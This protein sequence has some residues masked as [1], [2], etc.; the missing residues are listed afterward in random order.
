MRSALRCTTFAPSPRTMLRSCNRDGSR[1]ARPGCGAFVNADSDWK[2]LSESDP[3]LVA[4]L[5]AIGVTRL[6]TLPSFEERCAN[7]LFRRASG[8]AYFARPIQG[9]PIKIGYSA[10]P[11]LRAGSLHWRHGD[12]VE[13]LA[14][15]DGGRLRERELHG[16]FAEYRITGEWFAPVQEILDFIERPF[17]LLG[18]A[19]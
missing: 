8:Y 9:G 13:I 2:A 5:L 6:P 17:R 16:L 4:R 7:D 10:W 14:I 12:S 11:E 1:E 15:L 19:T 18:P 3:D